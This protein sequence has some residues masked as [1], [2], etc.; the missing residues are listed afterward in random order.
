[1]ERSFANPLPIEIVRELSRPKA[2]VAVGTTILTWSLIVSAA[3]LCEAHFNPLLYVVV[4]MWI[5]NQQHSLLIQ[6]HDGS[7]HRLA[8]NRYL[9]DVFAE[10]ACAWPMFF[11]MAAYRENHMLHHRYANTDRDPDFR[12]ERFPKSG[13]E[14]VK[15]LL[16]DVTA[17]NTVAHLGELKRLKKQTSL[18]TKLLRIAYYVALA[19][20]LTY[21]GA[22]KAYLLYWIVPLFTWV[23]VVLRM[24]AI[25]DHAGVETREFPFNTRTVIPNL[26]DRMFLAPRNCSYHIGHHLY[27]SVPWYNLKRL[28]EELM[29]DPEFQS[30]C[31][32]TRGF[33]RLL[34]EFPWRKEESRPEGRLIARVQE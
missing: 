31:Q 19:A 15:M 28:H 14:I 7:H 18:S 22:W 20:A 33:W 16:G 27:Q 9:N 32:I 30:R 8:K 10:L 21:F 13:R 25:A 3:W 23:K 12:P 1:M 29:K 17:L 2:W 11:R 34:L 24:R 6:M 26:F 4:V 5:G